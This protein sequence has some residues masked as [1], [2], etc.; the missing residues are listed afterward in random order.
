MPWVRFEPTITVF[1]RE[2][3]FHALD[4]KGTV[5]GNGP[6]GSIKKETSLALSNCHLLKKDYVPERDWL[7]GNSN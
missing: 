1:E 2:K 4:L 7:D 5:I 3:T 6:L